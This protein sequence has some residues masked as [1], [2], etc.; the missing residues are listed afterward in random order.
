MEWISLIGLNIIKI[1]ILNFLKGIKF[2]RFGSNTRKLMKRDLFSI[3][4]SSKIIEHWQI[5]KVKFLILSLHLFCFN[6]LH[7]WLLLQRC[8][9]LKTSYMSP[10][11]YCIYVVLLYTY[12][13]NLSFNKY[14]VLVF[15]L[16]VYTYTLGFYSFIYIYIYIY[17]LKLFKV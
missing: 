7:L 16:F 6:I 17:Y 11:A 12:N 13:E 14:D 10:Y 2:Q 15:I 1:I 8:L 5:I 9:K 3:K 4:L